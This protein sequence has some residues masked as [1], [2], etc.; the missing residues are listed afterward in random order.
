MN[1]V[2]C[3]RLTIFS[4]IFLLYIFLIETL[5]SQNRGA[6]AKEHCKCQETGFPGAK[7]N[8]R[9]DVVQTHGKEKCIHRKACVR[10][11]S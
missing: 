9:V 10:V 5:I 4:Y 3:S 8:L 6:R 1:S 7:G 11:A 2:I